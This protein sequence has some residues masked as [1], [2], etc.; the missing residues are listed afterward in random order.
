MTDMLKNR[1]FVAASL[2]PATQK[3]FENLY[4][5]YRL[6][7][8][9]ALEKMPSTWRDTCEVLVTNSLKGVGKEVLEKLPALRLVANFGTGVEKIDLPY[10]KKQNISVTHTP[11]VL[12]EDV[13]DLT[14]TLILATLRQVTAADRFVRRGAWAL[15]NFKLT[16]SFRG[17]NVGIVGM[18]KIGK[19]V[20]RLCLPFNT[21]IGYYGPNQKQV[22]YLYF[23]EV[24]SLADW[25]DVLVA[26]CPGGEPTKGIISAKVLDRL[27]A[28]GIFINISRGSVVD[29]KALVKRLVDGSIAGAG[30]DVFFN[31]P[32][33]PVQLMELDNVVL[34][35]HLGSATH[36]TR[37]EMG[38]LTL[39]NVAAFFEDKVLL[40]PVSM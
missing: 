37:R 21:N 20:A 36:R 16:R 38:N 26:A 34:Q 6:D 35:P 29:E 3:A 30:L 39:A 7:N 17:L 15:E 5:T 13:A 23:Q 19:E 14:L 4:E 33:V 31:E 1:I 2:Y 11:G 40:T 25:A 22:D 24:E 28:D 27:G 18:G 12:T 8:S 32:D 10:C 9:D